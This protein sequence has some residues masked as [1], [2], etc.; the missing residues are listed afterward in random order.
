[1]RTS[2]K[3]ALF[4]GLLALSAPACTSLLG[5]FDVTGGS[6]ATGAGGMGSSTSTS[7]GGSAA[8]STAASGGSTTS[9]GDGMTECVAG[10][11]CTDQNPCTTDA[12]DTVVGK[13]T[14]VAVPDGPDLAGADTPK[15]CLAPT[16]V[17][18]APKQAANDADLPDDG[19]NCTMD[20]CTG[21]VPSNPYLASSTACGAGQVCDGMGVCVGCVSS[22]QCA[23]P[24][25]CKSATCDMGACKNLN[26]SAGTSCGAAKVCDGGGSCVECVNDAGCT[27]AKI[28]ISGT[29]TTSC[30]TGA[31]DGTETDVDCG[32]LCQANC[33]LGKGC[34]N[35]NDCIS[36]LCT[37][38]KCAASAPT[39]FDNIK[40]GTE[41]DV[42]CGGTCALKC[43]TGG[44]CVTGS[45]CASTICTGNICTS[46]AP[47]CADG[48]T[49]GTE[50]DTDCGGGICL[51][52]GNSKSCQASSDCKSVSCVGNVCAATQC[53]DGAKNGGETSTDCGGP[54]C[55]KCPLTK[56]CFVNSDCLSNNCMA[57][58]CS[59]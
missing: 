24:G 11:A 37:N 3:A 40:N 51:P 42:D 46:S 16:C 57:L 53:S 22:N 7:A 54:S 12:C 21:G 26:D 9:T 14:H 25:T 19:N 15:D 41:A 5:D 2:S 52:C 23:D 45:D 10:D 49:N 58:I 43:A 31:K 48:M 29:C 8:T 13:C 47:T 55:T 56:S 30:N 1:M 59:P 32:G 33:G 18:G 20:V 44:T 6:T 35:N 36:N 28:C 39:C 17:G 50:T 27:G 38:L 34:K 4:L